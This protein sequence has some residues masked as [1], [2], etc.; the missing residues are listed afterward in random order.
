LGPK[1]G[2][3]LTDAA[4]LLHVHDLDP[5]RAVRARIADVVTVRRRYCNPANVL[6]GLQ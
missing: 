5:Q 4:R 3:R 2:E 1:D 6:A